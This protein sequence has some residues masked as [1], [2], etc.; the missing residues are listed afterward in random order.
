VPEEIQEFLEAL[1]RPW[2]EAWHTYRMANW[3]DLVDAPELV[4]MNAQAI[5]G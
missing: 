4:L 5:L 3:L 2:L 1:S